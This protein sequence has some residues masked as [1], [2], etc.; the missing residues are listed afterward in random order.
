M[1]IAGKLLLA[2]SASLA[3]TG[4]ASAAHVTGDRSFTIIVNDISTDNTLRL[5]DGTTT[6]VPVAPGAY[7][8]VKDGTW[9]F[10]PGGKAGAGLE[11][12]ARMAN[13][14]PLSHS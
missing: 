7:A 11:R 1:N 3:L 5:P 6:N 8:I 10:G 13:R 14:T 12:L 2:M 9:I 4:V